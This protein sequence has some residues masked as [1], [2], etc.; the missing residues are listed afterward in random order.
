MNMVVAMFSRIGGWRFSYE[1]VFT[2]YCLIFIYSV[3]SPYM[4]M[5]RDD[6]VTCYMR[7]DDV[8]GCVSKA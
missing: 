1:C 2:L 4:L 3:S 7:A 5:F 8:L 6:C